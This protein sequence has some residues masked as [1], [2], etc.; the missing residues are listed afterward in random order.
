MDLS[1]V[2]QGFWDQ[3][4]REYL[5]A[6]RR[7]SEYW[8]LELEREVAAGIPFSVDMQRAQRLYV[9]RGKGL[10]QKQSYDPDAERL[11][12]G[13]LYDRI[14]TTVKAH[15]Q[16]ARILVLTC[17]PGGLCLELARQGHRVVGIDLSEKTIEI[18]RKFAKDNPIKE[19]FGALEYRI[20][21]LNT[22]DLDP[23]IYDVVIV[24]DGLHHILKIDRLM[25]QVR[26]SLKSDGLFIYSDNVGLHRFS[27]LLGGILYLLLPTHVSYWQKLKFALAGE[28]RIRE[29][30]RARSPFEEISTDSILSTSKKYFDI[31]ESYEHTGIGY[32]AAIV[33]DLNCPRG[34]KL[35]FIRCLKKFDDWAVRHRLLKGD[36]VLV[37]AVPAFGKRY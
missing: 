18:A 37:V 36:H 30:M 20:A 35:L 27:R 25:R 10:P 23:G 17:G 4:S 24:W 34:V 3:N 13:P 9:N 16:N 7:E 28:R 33:G 12:N 29:E 6:C 5:Q 15:R 1:M 11:L 22:A 19:S 8:G 26:G 2:E 31:K 14:F 32:R 21:D